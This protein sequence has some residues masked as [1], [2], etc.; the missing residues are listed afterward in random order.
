MSS[1]L[2][3]I[4]DKNF[5]SFE[6]VKAFFTSAPY[7]FEV[8]ENSQLY[9]LCMT[10]KSDVSLAE[11]REATGIMFEKE[12]NKLIHYS[13]AKAYEGITTEET[14]ASIEKDLFYTGKIKETDSVVIDYYFEGSM[15]KLYNYLDSWKIATSKHLNADNNRWS[16][17]KTFQDLFKECVP[18]SFNCTYEEFEKSLDSKYCYT[19]LFQHPEHTMAL[20]VA[21][22]LC[23][24]IN[25]VN[26]ET[27][28]EDN[29]EQGSLT[30]TLK[31]LADID[32][33]TS[34]LTQNYLVYHLN[35][36]GKILNRIKMLSNKFLELKEKL[37]NYP[38]VGLKY[39]EN[40]KNPEKTDEL[41]SYYPQYQED[42]ADIDF[43]FIKT[44]KAIYNA[45]IRKHVSRAQHEFLP[46]SYKGIIYDLHGDYLSTKRPV[47]LRDVINMVSALEPRRLAAVINYTY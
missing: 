26:L 35:S 21:T 37:G 6:E 47:I 34:S 43:L 28:E 20:P 7:F 4:N 13:F 11:T 5:A 41:R 18:N 30:T 33:S 42:F 16:S 19:F 46:K 14:P 15:I 45:Y 32:Q 25:R 3:L 22:P 12:T 39:L 29:E 36:E 24:P 10:E 2:A 38:N 1:L 44:C 8:K 40:I 31:S 27:T 9:M 17:K 23:F